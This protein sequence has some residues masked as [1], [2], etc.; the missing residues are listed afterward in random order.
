MISS[1]LSESTEFE[2]SADPA[3]APGLSESAQP[4]ESAAKPQRGRKSGRRQ[5][6]RRRNSRKKIQHALRFRENGTLRVLQLADVQDGPDVDSDTVALIE[7]AV[8]AADPDLVVLTG[9]QVRG[10]DAA[11]AP[12][13]MAR[14]GDEPGARLPLPMRVEQLL[15]EC[16]G[17]AG[18]IDDAIADGGESMAGTRA[19]I[20]HSFSQ[21]L[22]PIVSRGI[23]FAA[24]Y[25]NHDF[26][27]GILPDEQDDMYRE[28]AGCLNPK[29]EDGAA[30]AAGPLAC[31]PGTFALPIASHDGKRTAM[32]IMMVNSG[33][34]EPGGGY[35][36]PSDAAVEW[37]ASAEDAVSGTGPRVPAIVFQHIPPQDF[38]QCLKK[39]SPFTPYAVEGYRAFS[40]SC[41]VIN[42]E[43]CRPGSTLGEG[44]CCSERAVG[45]VER[46]RSS[47]GYFALFCGHDHKNNFIGHIDGVDLGY[48]P[49]CGFRS[50]GPKAADR[51]LRL[52]VFQEDKPEQYETR[53]LTYG[54]LVSRR[55]R[56]P[57][58]LL[59]GEYMI[60]GPS[61]VRDLLRRPKIFIGMCLVA[62][63]TL[64]TLIGRRSSPK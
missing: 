10:Y 54:D 41:Y 48:A 7:R 64:F 46:I 19:K 18:R 63:Q 44:P 33:D 53:L 3:D 47:G 32:S 27:C 55:V 1:E 25:G 61:S 8:I 40:D 49:T 13:F 24:T 35:G 21:F 52:F 29:V 34:F 2:P 20:R 59:A 60:S 50:Y 42:S 30:S 6:S 58:R 17:P 12:T 9:D 56:H 51:A 28:F 36:S 16:N 15:A 11:Y 57:L 26:Q 14:R 37:L 38:Y 43:V 39:A 5:P 45:E 62:A 23:P 31:E 4:A 22:G